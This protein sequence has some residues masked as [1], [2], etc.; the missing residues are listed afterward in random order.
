M[1]LVS[2]SG[3]K[4][5]RGAR[6]R[7]GKGACDSWSSGKILAWETSA[8]TEHWL[9]PLAVRSVFQSLSFPICQAR[10]SA[11][12]C[13]ALTACKRPLWALPLPH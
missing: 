11:Q 8:P 10:G 4:Q 6:M 3:E 1:V 12:A 2:K 9:L 7:G 13:Y 5:G